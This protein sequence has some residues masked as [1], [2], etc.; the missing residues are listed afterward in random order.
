MLSVI[1]AATAVTM[2][3]PQLNTLFLQFVNHYVLGFVRSIKTR[4]YFAL[5]GGM[6]VV[7][8]SSI[9]M[10]SVRNRIENN[11]QLQ[12]LVLRKDIRGCIISLNYR[13]VASFQRAGERFDRD[14]YAARSKGLGRHG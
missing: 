1:D 2:D 4:S 3:R 6:T 5:P 10:S 11:A 9:A 14:F 8:S 12:S 7:V 13:G